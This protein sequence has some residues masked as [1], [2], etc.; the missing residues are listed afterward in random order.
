LQ[1]IYI[2]CKCEGKHYGLGIQH[3]LLWIWQ[4]VLTC[5]PLKW[6]A[7]MP[8]QKWMTCYN[9]YSLHNQAKGIKYIP[10]NLHLK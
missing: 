10:Q 7:R 6:G 3:S 9:L 8:I 2:M 4:Q 5:H 1:Y